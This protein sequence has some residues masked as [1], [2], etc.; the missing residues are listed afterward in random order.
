MSFPVVELFSTDVSE[1]FGAAGVM[2][3]NMRGPKSETRNRINKI[4]K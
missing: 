3:Y 4:H 2:I 1:E